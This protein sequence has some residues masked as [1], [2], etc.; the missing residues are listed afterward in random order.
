MENKNHVV[1]CGDLSLKISFQSNMHC[2]YPRDSSGAREMGIPG[3]TPLF[4]GVKL[5]REQSLTLVVLTSL[6]EVWD[7]QGEETTVI[8]IQTGV[9]AD[10]DAAL[11]R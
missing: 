1:R 6:A 10:D 8:R 11:H 3:K 2:R 9:G 4:P 5:S 7:K